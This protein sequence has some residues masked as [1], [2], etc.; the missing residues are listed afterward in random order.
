MVDVGDDT[1]I[2]ETV[3]GDCGDALF[4]GSFY[5]ELLDCVRDGRWVE[6]ADIVRDCRWSG[7]CPDIDEAIREAWA[8]SHQFFLGVVMA[9]DAQWCSIEVTE[10]IFG[11]G[12]PAETCPRCELGLCFGRDS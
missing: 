7:A 4:E 11:E 10:I 12:L 9:L 2:A 1:E 3:D 8:S 5:F 6:E